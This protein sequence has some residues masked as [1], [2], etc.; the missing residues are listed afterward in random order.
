M[1]EYRKNDVLEK[2]R[3]AFEAGMTMAKMARR[4]HLPVGPPARN[5]S[6]EWLYPRY[7]AFNESWKEFWDKRKVFFWTLK[8]YHAERGRDV[9]ELIKVLFDTFVEQL[10]LMFDEADLRVAFQD[11]LEQVD[12]SITNDVQLEFNF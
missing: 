10:S 3:A 8:Q 4:Y 1:K 5:V 2:L 11:V 7:E 12:K 9:P 6:G